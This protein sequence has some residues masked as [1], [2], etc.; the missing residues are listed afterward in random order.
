M[1]VT[2][3]PIPGTGEDARL[4][5]TV[6][7]SGRYDGALVKAISPECAFRDAVRPGDRILTNGDKEVRGGGDL[8]AAEDDGSRR[9]GIVRRCRRE[10]C[11]RWARPGGACA[12][13]SPRKRRAEG[14][15]RN[16]VMRGG[17]CKRHHRMEAEAGGGADG[18][19]DGDGPS[20]GRVGDAG[21]R[22]AT[23]P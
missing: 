6:V 16:G 22:G 5:L 15:A 21:G 8:V 18:A 13:H 9:Y 17:L 10:G 3:P 20:S 19:D 12:A 1:F 7:F 4:G 23:R 11:D 2:I 14:C